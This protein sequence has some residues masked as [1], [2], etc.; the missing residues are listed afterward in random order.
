MQTPNDLFARQWEWDRLT[1]LIERTKPEPQLA[2]VYGRRRQGKTLLTARL[3]EASGGFY[4]EAFDG[5]LTQNLVSLST[6][7]STW[8]RSSTPLRFES[9]SEALRAVLSAGAIA[10]RPVPVVLDEITRVITR[11]PEFPSLLQH[12][13][14]P[15]GLGAAAGGTTLILC[16]SAFGAMRSLLDGPAPLPGRAALELIVQ[17]FDYRTASEFW[18][19]GSNPAAAFAHN[20]YVGGTPAYRSLA[21]HHLPRHGDVDSWVIRRV[22]DPSSSLFR[23]GR[24]VIAEDP[25]LGDQQRYWGLLAAIIDGASR[26]SDLE[27]VLGQRRGSLQHAINVA[28]DAG[29]IERHDDPLRANRSTYAVTE[30]MI[31]F[32]RLIIEPNQQRLNARRAADVWRDM[33][34]TVAAQILAPHME[35]LAR[36]WLVRYA[37]PDATGGILTK[38]GSTRTLPPP[39]KHE[40]AAATPGRS[41]FNE[42]S[43]GRS[44]FDIAGVETTSRGATKLILLGEVKSTDARVGL[45]ELDRLDRAIATRDEGAACKRILVSRAGFTTDLERVAARRSEVELVDLHRLY[46][47][48]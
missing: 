48:D 42:P 28:I 23:E 9:W 47:G 43:I 25:Q 41:S 4:W 21:D 19:L 20:A 38:A 30:P 37:S 33:R 32:H 3:C 31:R 39:A 45:G 5:E 17:P 24:I 11:M 10:G 6:A 14:G 34:P 8:S 40:S 26:W 15:A 29:W 22:L 1:A 46:H 13:L 35:T 16:G 2:L 36:E 27:N 7:W 12:L 18:G 44:Q